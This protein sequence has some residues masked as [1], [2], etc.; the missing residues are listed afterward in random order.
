MEFFEPE[1]KQT[2]KLGQNLITSADRESLDVPSLRKEVAKLLEKYLD[3][4]SCLQE[5][6]AALQKIALNVSPLDKKIN[7]LEVWV[8]DTAQC[9]GAGPHQPN[10]T[11]LNKQL[12]E[13]GVSDDQ[14]SRTT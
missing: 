1:V 6:E 2:V 13:T 11:V 4:N 12:E 3:L 10:P 7:E 9:F 8:T 5:V 14:L